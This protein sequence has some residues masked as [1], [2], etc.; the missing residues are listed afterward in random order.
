MT[1]NTGISV[2]TIDWGKA[3]DIFQFPIAVLLSPLGAI[4][5][6]YM[7][8]MYSLT[9][10]IAPDQLAHKR[11]AISTFL[12]VVGILGAVGVALLAQY[13][14]NRNARFRENRERRLDHLEKLMLTTIEVT[15][16]IQKYMA[17]LN[18]E[19]ISGKLQEIF[20]Q[21][22]ILRETAFIYEFSF[23]EDVEKI[24]RA[25]H[26][27]STTKFSITNTEDPL[28]EFESRK[29]MNTH[30][31]RIRYLRAELSKLRITIKLE[32]SHIEKLNQ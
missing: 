20:N 17:L 11:W 23:Q 28:D 19:E 1:I 4:P 15:D 8:I 18:Q 32:H 5:I 30:A 31:E 9:F 24:Q 2:I 25:L 7:F 3:R 27:L 29:N 12:Y 10:D 14:F 21:L 22:S 26:Q 16:K 13:I 6:L